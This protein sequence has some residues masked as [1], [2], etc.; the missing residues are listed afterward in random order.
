M[1]L[2]LGPVPA[3]SE[4]LLVDFFPD[5]ENPPFHPHCMIQVTHNVTCKD[6][7]FEFDKAIALPTFDPAGGQYTMKEQIND[8]TIWLTHSLTASETTYIDDIEF[9]YIDTSDG[10]CEVHAKSRSQA[11]LYW[12]YNTNY[13]NMY[14]LARAS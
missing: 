10:K 1:T 9:S 13:C 8:N 3:M 7:M 12:D 5:L 2:T 11:A 14:N 6:L 4:S